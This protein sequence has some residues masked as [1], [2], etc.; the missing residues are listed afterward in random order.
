MSERTVEIQAQLAQ[1]K[2][3]QQFN[4][5]MEASRPAT[6]GAATRFTNQ[7]NIS[8]YSYPIDLMNPEKPYAGNYVVFYINVHED[9]SLIRENKVAVVEGN[10][11]TR[12]KGFLAGQ[13]MDDEAVKKSAVI[14]NAMSGGA[15]GAIAGAIGANNISSL[16]AAGAIIGGLAT[17]AAV[18]SVGKI[19][20]EYK[21]IQQAIALYMPMDMNISYGVNWMDENMAGVGALFGM[22]ENVLKAITDSSKGTEGR[23]DEILN[24]FGTAKSF[25]S[26]AVLD[27]TPVGQAI[28]KTSGVA[29]NPKK[30]QIFKSVNHREFTFTYQFFSRSPEEAQAVHNII[31]LFKMHMHPEYKTNTGNFLYVYPSEFDIFYYNN[32]VENMNVHRHTSCVLTNMNVRYTPLG[33]YVSF[34]DGSPTQVDVTLNF[35]ELALL[36]KELIEDG[37]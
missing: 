8:Q 33:Q 36:S 25:T 28:S 6:R 10:I 16:P 22:G 31:K 2:A 9:S 7:Y 23:I 21:R 13:Q 12:T 19:K 35:R 30:E 15:A 37:F 27:A 29:A 17:T 5:R 4:A 14:V 3:S 20:A 26:G 24:A 18:D 1:E 11:P 32:G 34:A